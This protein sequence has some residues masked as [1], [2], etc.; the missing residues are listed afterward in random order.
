MS[1]STFAKA[2]NEALAVLRISGANQ[3]QIRELLKMRF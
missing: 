3:E 2:L 1:A